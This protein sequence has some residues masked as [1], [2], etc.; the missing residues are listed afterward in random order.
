MSITPTLIATEILMCGLKKLPLVG[1]AVEV[2]EAVQ[3]KH[4][5]L[6]MSARLN[7]CEGG[8]SELQKWAI[9][10]E[11]AVQ[12]LRS[13]HLDTQTANQHVRQLLQMQQHGLAPLLFAGLLRDIPNWSDLN[14][15]PN[16][17]G[18]LLDDRECLDPNKLKVLIDA[19][20][21]RILELAPY[22]LAT[23]LSERAESAGATSILAAEDI[24]A[25][26]EKT[27]SQDTRLRCFADPTKNVVQ[28][29][30]SA[31]GCKVHILYDNNTKLTANAQTGQE[32]RRQELRPYVGEQMVGV[33]PDGRMAFSNMEGLWDFET[34]KLKRM[35][36]RRAHS[37]VSVIFSPDTRVAL[38]VYRHGGQPLLVWDVAPESLGAWFSRDWTP[39]RLDHLVPVQT[40]IAIASDSR[41][42]VISSWELGDR[43]Y[44]GVMKLCDLRTG[45]ETRSIYKRNDNCCAT[46]V[47][48]SPNLKFLGSVSAYLSIWEVSSGMEFRRLEQQAQPSAVA[49]SPD[50][51]SVLSG[52]VD[53]TIRFWELATGRERDCIKGHNGEVQS[54]TFSQNGLQVLSTGVDNTVTL[55]APHI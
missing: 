49:F 54:V 35:S 25:F 8:L 29:V 36:K 12:N 27:C 52:H 45:K 41:H 16:H 46:A 17:Y 38:S 20:K 9:Q 2:V 11:R 14:M 10:I 26:P 21:P 48:V 13:P 15:S 1:A 43:Y 39:M 55:W 34:G 42:A 50:G 32:M 19:D 44:G 7:R 6:V 30:F 4:A 40:A 3:S 22:A 18:T 31:D 24:W 5:Q 53:G 51:R 33:S 28:A 37:D 47:A 23:L